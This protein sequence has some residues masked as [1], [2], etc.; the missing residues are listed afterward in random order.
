M[1]HLIALLFPPICSDTPCSIP[2]A[3][4]ME[5]HSTPRKQKTQIRNQEYDHMM[6]TKKQRKRKF[7][8]F[9]LLN[10]FTYSM[11]VESK[12]PDAAEAKLAPFKRF[13]PL[14]FKLR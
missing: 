5:L 12:K 13:F 4:S 3:G 2:A 9:K 1:Q 10:V 6:R 7:L 14:V 11:A 8:S